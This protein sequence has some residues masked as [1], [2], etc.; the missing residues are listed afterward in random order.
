MGQFKPP[1][2]S[3]SDEFLLLS[4]VRL[5][6]VSLAGKS[7]LNWL[8]LLFFTVYCCT[9]KQLSTETVVKNFLWWCLWED[10][11]VGLPKNEQ[12][13]RALMWV[14]GLR[15]KQ[16]SAVWKQVDAPTVRPSDDL[17]KHSENWRNIWSFQLVSI[18]RLRPRKWRCKCRSHGSEQDH[19]CLDMLKLHNNK[20]KGKKT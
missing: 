6:P 1:C 9:V 13:S 2:C 19:V 12:H 11:N 7:R 18:S 8:R 3:S 5:R 10:A 20:P 16:R 4:T 14:S 17:S 15:G